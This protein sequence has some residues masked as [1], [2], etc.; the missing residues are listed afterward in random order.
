M[1]KFLL[2]ITVL[3]SG[4]VMGQS[5]IPSQN[6]YTEDFTNYG[7]ELGSGNFVYHV[8]LFN[9]ETM[10]PDF[11]LQ[12]NQYYNA[13]AA[14]SIYTSTQPIRGWSYDYLPNIYRKINSPFWDESYYRVNSADVY[15]DGEP[16][17]KPKRDDDTFHIDMFGLKAAFSLKYNDNDTVTVNLK[18]SNVYLEVIPHC[19]MSSGEGDAKI[20]NLMGFTVKDGNGFT[21][22]FNLPEESQFRPFFGPLLSEFLPLLDLAVDNPH[23]YNNYKKA[24]L[25]SNIT[26]KY[27]RSLVQYHYT[28]HPATNPGD[29]AYNRKDIDHIEVVNKAKIYIDNGITITDYR[30][31]L[32]QKIEHGSSHVWF[33]DR[34][35]HLFNGYSFIYNPIGSSSSVNVYGNHLKTGHCVDPSVESWTYDNSVQNYT[36]GLLKTIN[37][38]NKGKI[39]IEYETNTYTFIDLGQKFNQ[40]NYEYVQVP[41][42]YNSIDHTYSFTFGTLAT[43]SDEGYYVQFEST[44]YT[45]PLLKDENGNPLRVYPGLRIYGSGGSV[46]EGFSYEDQCEYGGRVSGVYTNSTVVLHRHSGTPVNIS[47][48]KVYKKMRKPQSEWINYC[49]GPSV[50]VKKITTTDHTSTVVNEK[51]YSYQDPANPK[52]SSGVVHDYRWYLYSDMLF[53][54]F[55]R[56]IT[57]EET[58]KGKT[59]YQMNMDT[60]LIQARPQDYYYHPKNI[61]KYDESGQLKEH[62][63]NEFEYFSKSSRIRKTTSVVKTYEGTAFKTTSTEKVLDTISML[64][65]YNKIVDTGTA[66]TFEEQYTSQK[67]GNAFYRTAVQKNK[68]GLVLNK[69]T[70][71]YQQQGI[72]QAYNLKT[73]SVAKENRPLEVEKEVTLTDNYGNV[74]EYKTKDGMVVSQV[75]GYNDSKLVAELKNVPYANITANASSTLTAIKTHSAGATFNEANLAT[76]LNSLRTAF[77][78]AFVTTYTYIP[79]VGI[80]T[81]TDANAQKE[82]YQYDDFNRLYRVLNHEG[83][84]IKEYTYNIKN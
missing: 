76:A 68:N 24:F 60:S 57:E 30:N 49:F 1:K 17:E 20:I 7:A 8:P 13:Q 77:T 71:T 51:S 66:Q 48:V 11:N 4:I 6:N 47:N 46:R 78:N 83:L 29:T 52:I 39:N 10:N 79:L 58:G 18:Y 67:L 73:V 62:L 82:T 3:A 35:N 15:G 23:G 31:Q 41:V 26:D 81:V 69:S 16:Y 55:Y 37:L 59:V 61:W 25:L 5:I 63:N 54:I 22:L 12:G 75:W 45:D 21:Y 28:G 74:L 42:T 38:P 72:T 43:G 65:L 40:L 19:P 56:Y 84:V 9:I 27:G 70:F 36:A 50:R 32:I 44:L 33:Y 14:S 34:N 53:P 64:P 2:F 80:S